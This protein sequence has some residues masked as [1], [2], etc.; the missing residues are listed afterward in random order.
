MNSCRWL[1]GHG[2]T[3]HRCGDKAQGKVRLYAAWINRSVVVC[4][5]HRDRALELGWQD[6]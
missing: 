4:A 3:R 2:R 6:A 1:V 5:A